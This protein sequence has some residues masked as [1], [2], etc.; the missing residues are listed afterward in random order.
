VANKEYI[1]RLAAAIRHLHGCEAKHVGS[2]TVHEVFR[3]QT[4]WKG[5][6]QIFD[7]TGHVKAK[8]AYGWSYPEGPHDQGER[9][10]TVLELPPVSSPEAAVKAAVATEIKETRKNLKN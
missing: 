2:K 4:I 1:R 9:F 5:D 7:L 6:V 3:G 8:R 10:V